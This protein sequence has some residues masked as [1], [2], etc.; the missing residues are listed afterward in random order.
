MASEWR[1][2]PVT[3]TLEG[4]PAGV[5]TAREFAAQRWPACP[6]CGSQINVAQISVT[7]ALD[8]FPKYMI[9]RWECDLGCDPRTDRAP[10][11]QA[12]GRVVFA[13]RGMEPG[14]E[15]LMVGVMDTAMLAEMVV[16]ALNRRDAAGVVPGGLPDFDG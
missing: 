1:I 7:S 5:M 12:S 3:F 8:Q 4:G 13:Q 11:Y 16:D 6:V 15:D 14:D 2:N 9:G 10:V